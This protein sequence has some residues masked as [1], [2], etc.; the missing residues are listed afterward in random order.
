MGHLKFFNQI[1]A[2]PLIQS[3]REALGEAS[4]LLF[5]FYLRGFYS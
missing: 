4:W 1:P 2:N 3:Q 5:A